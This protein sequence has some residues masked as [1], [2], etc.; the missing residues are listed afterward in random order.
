M[1]ICLCGILHSPFY[2][3]K[4]FFFLS[5]ITGILKEVVKNMGYWLGCLKL[6]SGCVTPQ[7]GVRE[8]VLKLLCV[9][10]LLSVKGNNNRTS[11]IGFVER[12]KWVNTSKALSGYEEKI[13]SIYH[14]LTL[15][16]LNLGLI[17]TPLC[18]RVKKLA[19][20]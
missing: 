5:S 12:I 13:F 9:S 6:Y 4:I 11:L 19:E 10:V 17:Q 20:N 15:S 2:F 3:V 16:T 18:R 1:T 8:Q 14:I 7:L